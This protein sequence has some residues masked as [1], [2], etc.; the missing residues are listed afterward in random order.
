MIALTK[1]EIVTIKA[2]IAVLSDEQ[3]RLKLEAGLA[4][5]EIKGCEHGQAS[6]RDIDTAEHAQYV[7]QLWEEEYAAE[8]K[9][10]QSK[11]AHLPKPY[12]K[13]QSHI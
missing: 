11:V 2:R 3:A 13:L 1:Q 5:D 6:H 8:L 9:Q 12:F 10:L 7:V 4:Q